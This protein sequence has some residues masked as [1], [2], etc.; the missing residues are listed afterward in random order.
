MAEVDNINFDVSSSLNLPS[1][2]DKNKVQNENIKEEKH[3]EKAIKGNVKIKK[4]GFLSKFKKSMVSEDANGVG[5]YV[6]KD[7]VIPAIKD[8]IFDAARGALEMVLYG[9]HSRR[10]SRNDRVNYSSISSGSYQYGRNSS[11][12][13]SS[14]PRRNRVDDFEVREVIFESRRDAE[15]ALSAL[16]MVLEEYPSVSVGDFYDALGQSAPHTTLNY[17]W[18]NLN[19]AKVKPCKDG[20]YID[21]PDPKPIK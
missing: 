5:D 19:D 2:S 11:K 7:I 12:R 6:F 9:D 16:L 18:T 15:N 1:M 4:K 13:E 21:F 8:V 17:G 20:Y 3:I 14:E 10:R